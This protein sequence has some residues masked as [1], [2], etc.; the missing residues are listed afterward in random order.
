MA[1]LHVCIRS[2]AFEY[3]LCLLGRGMFL[4]N[5]GDFGDKLVLDVEQIYTL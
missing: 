4:T 5:P 2:T 1:T 3:L